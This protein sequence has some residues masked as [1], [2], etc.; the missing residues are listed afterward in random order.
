MRFESWRGRVA[1]G[2][3][4]LA[5]VYGAGLLLTI[6]V[7]PTVDDRTL[8]Q[9]G[10]PWSLA[11]FAQPLLVSAMMWHVLRRRCHGG[12]DRATTV[13]WTLASVY[14][15]YSVVGGF[16]IAAGALPAALLLFLAV[17]LAP[18]EIAPNALPIAGQ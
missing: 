5:G 4:V 11:I 10:G 16:S 9:H 3:C 8:L 17:A 1:A 7:I 15:I 12:S 18:R 14:L 6:T 2:L 13:A